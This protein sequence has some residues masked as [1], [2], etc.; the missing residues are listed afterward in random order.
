M[1]RYIINI[2]YLL[3][4]SVLLGVFILSAGRLYASDS[5]S[6]DSIINVPDYLIAQWFRG[7]DTEPYDSSTWYRNTSFS[8]YLNPEK[9]WDRS[10]YD[11]NLFNFGFS[12][13][14]E[15]NPSN[16]IAI[17]MSFATSDR[18]DFYFRR[19]GLDLGY[20]WNITN[21]YY[22]FS[23]SRRYTFLAT[24]GV[25]LGKIKASDNYNKGYYGGYLGLRVNRTFSPHTSFFVEPRLGLYSDSYDAMSNP[26][27]FD[28]LTTAHLGLNYKL[29]ETLNSVKPRK[30]IDP[31]HLKNWFFEV[32]SDVFLPVPKVD[33]VSADSKYSERINYGASL[34]IGYRVN[35]L[36]SAR[37]RLSYAKDRYSSIKQYIGA[38]D[39]MISGTNFFL[40]EN[41]RRYADMALILGPV[42]ELSKQNE[43]EKM[44]LSWGA[45]AG[46]QFTRRISPTFEL[47]FE[48]RLQLVQDYT[49]N[50]IDDPGLK[51]RW[52]MNLGMIYIYQKRIRE[53]RNAWTPMQNWYIQALLGAQTKTLSG[54]HQLGSFD[55]SLGHDYG[56]L[57]STRYSVFSGELKSNEPKYDESWNPMYVSY[58][59]GRAEIVLNFMRM[60]SPAF[61]KSR[62][63]WNFSGGIE[64]GRLSNHY[65]HDF[66][67]VFGSQLQYLYAKNTWITAGARVQK[68]FKFEPE[69][70]VTAFVGVQY[71]LD[72]ER[73]ID[74][75]QNYW[76]WYVQGGTG[77]RNAFFNMDNISYNLALG[78]NF[79]PEYGARLQLIGTKSDKTTDGTISNWMSLSPEYVYNITNRILGQDDNR[80]VDIEAISGIDFMI[81]NSNLSHTKIG[82]SVGAQVNANINKSIALFV[83]PRFSVQPFDRIIA[84]TGHDKVQYFTLLGLRY[85][86]NRFYAKDESQFRYM[87]GDKGYAL[88]YR[89]KD[90]IRNIQN[91]HPFEDF[92]PFGKIKEWHPL[93]NL[94]IINQKQ[95][96]DVWHPLQ[97]WYFQT[98]WDA[99]LESIPTGHQIGSFDFVVGRNITPL[100]NIQASVFSG[101]LQSEEPD[102]DESYNP[103]FVSYYGGRAEVVFNFLRLFSPAIKD[104]RWNWNVSGGVEMGH[105]SNHYHKDYALVAGSQ[106]QYRVG[107]HAWITAGGRF[108]KLS[109]F[110]AKLPLSGVLGIQYDLRNERR[111]DILHNR[112]RWYVQGNA[113][114]HNSFFNMDN[115]VYGGAL[116]MNITPNHGMRI[117]FV[118]TKQNKDNDG[119]L[120]NWMSLSPEYVFNLTNRF[121]GEDDKRRVDM[122][123]FA[124]VDFMI[125]DSEFR[126][127]NS[128]T[129]FSFGT[130]INANINK[131]ISLFI[132]PRFS[133]Q[134][135][136]RIIAPT[137]HDKVQ[138]FTLFGIRYSHNKFKSLKQQ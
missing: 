86:H 109:E 98:L 89:Y 91:W 117:E 35:P 122:E 52:D 53:R 120:Y 136:D 57:F 130:Q 34:G 1:N 83:E 111:I 43:V 107:S 104:S 76:R 58:F 29:S 77:F 38:V 68:L 7:V 79:T 14:K 131:S 103:M 100:W 8:L 99:Q 31:L 69:L 138:Y 67:V 37:V 26:E 73:R 71:D 82:F 115:T 4:R 126:F 61:E 94:H 134:P 62:W 102:Y 65:H 23:R 110:D 123:L 132:Q 128:E 10:R 95:R 125:H 106:L 50:E 97:K 3:T 22:G 112:W 20:Q 135:F 28:A 6:K 24:T 41:E 64:G 81:H 63:N 116:G 74:L 2:I 18:N 66:G 42:F 44:H 105:L 70:P 12:L 46:L 51:K 80:I 13:N 40:G 127:R 11:N 114:F 39:L 59:G 101:T 75:L 25:E 49:R 16:A 5:T 36:S 121:L 108:E 118:G 124:G 47:F 129:G 84:P 88:Y 56:P 96:N 45:E 78:M 60:W 55:I 9:M 30:E 19:F 133:V 33:Y 48:P 93:Q 85:A 21:F 17:G 137:G 54:E 72:N 90:I 119:T 32:G 113:G 92:H 87:F 15:F 27:G